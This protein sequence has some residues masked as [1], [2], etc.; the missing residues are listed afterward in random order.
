MQCQ[1]V[2]T[3]QYY[4]KACVSLHSVNCYNS[5]DADAIEMDSQQSSMIT[6]IGQL[7]RNKNFSTSSYECSAH[8]L[9]CTNLYNVDCSAFC[10]CKLP[11]GCPGS[12]FVIPICV[13]FCVQIFHNAFGANF[14]AMFSNYFLSAD[15]VDSVRVTLQ[16]SL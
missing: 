14:F 11:T 1:E 6:L 3:H 10:H 7:I 8:C 5:V 16:M 12:S 15:N 13:L 9:V 2:S 4:H